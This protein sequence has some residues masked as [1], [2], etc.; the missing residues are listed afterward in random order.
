MHPMDQDGTIPID[1]ALPAS[2]IGTSLANS[3]GGFEYLNVY[4]NTGSL[5]ESHQAASEYDVYAVINRGTYD[6][7]RLEVTGAFFATDDL[8][9]NAIPA[10]GAI[11]L[12][13]IGAGLV[14]WLR[15]CRTT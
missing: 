13:S 4:D 5:P 1:L 12:G 8:Q 10:P 3:L 6:I 2:M 7:S 15:R 11:L 14:G 9:F